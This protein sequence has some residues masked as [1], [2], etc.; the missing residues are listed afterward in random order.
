MSKRKNFL[1]LF[2]GA[3][4]LFLYQCEIKL[5]CKNPELGENNNIKDALFINGKLVVLSSP[6]D[7]LTWCS[8]FITVYELNENSSFIPTK[9]VGLSGKV[10]K[11]LGYINEKIVVTLQ[12]KEALEIL[13]KEINPIGK[14]TLQ[15]SDIYHLAYLENSFAISSYI[16]SKI[17]IVNNPPKFFG[18]GGN[19]GKNIL[20]VD[21]I[22]K[23]K[24]F[25]ISDKFI[26]F[27]KNKNYVAILPENKDIIF[28][29]PIEVLH[30]SDITQ[31]TIS[32]QSSFDFAQNH[33]SKK[34]G[35]KE[36]S[37]RNIK[38][39]HHGIPNGNF[40]AVPSFLDN[41]TGILIIF[42]SCLTEFTG[43]DYLDDWKFEKCSIF[44]DHPLLTEMNISEF[45]F[46]SYRDYDKK[47]IVF[48][49]F[50]SDFEKNKTIFSLL[51]YD[52]QNNKFLVSDFKEIGTSPFY[53]IYKT[54]VKDIIFKNKEGETQMNKTSATNNL[55]EEREINIQM[56]FIKLKNQD[57]FEII[58]FV[59]D[60][61][62]R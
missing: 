37:N 42:P 40:V 50:I 2:I 10:A 33:V 60:Y 26:S 38:F 45:H 30:P 46:W 48:T 28:E 31:A 56:H 58:K 21:D 51:I 55:Q 36:N 62:I 25:I 15:L 1:A 44:F 14:I 8:S 39:L 5:N 32:G 19:D 11:R 22:R 43:S 13:D 53:L 18:S 4:T 41:T 20:Q 16:D 35:K 23:L 61:K 49:F 29:L 12:D 17:L 54:E 57:E 7:V 3:I 24:G 27:I 47:I 9:V 34:I 59:G 6:Q 52:Y